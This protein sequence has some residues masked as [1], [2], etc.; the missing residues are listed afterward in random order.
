MQGF[1]VGKHIIEIFHPSIQDSSSKES[2]YD[3]AT[4]TIS[5]SE[6]KSFFVIKLDGEIVLLL[7]LVQE[8]TLDL[9]ILDDPLV[10]MRR[11]KTIK[12]TKILL[13]TILKLTSGIEEASNSFEK[14]KKLSNDDEEK[15]KRGEK[16]KVLRK[17]VDLG[18][19]NKNS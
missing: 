8:N 4:L 10:Q 7:D 17:N 11:V 2:F 15:R 3:L 18:D 5:Q 1:K 9:K 13:S 12:L 14:Y 6:N 19:L 16:I